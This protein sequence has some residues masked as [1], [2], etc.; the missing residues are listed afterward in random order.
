MAVSVSFFIQLFCFVVARCS[1]VCL[2]ERIVLRG[3]AW[4][5]EFFRTKG[6]DFKLTKRAFIVF[7]SMNSAR[8]VEPKQRRTTSTMLKVFGGG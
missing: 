3:F 8:S 2:S 1:P 6:G 4:V 7:C 5:L